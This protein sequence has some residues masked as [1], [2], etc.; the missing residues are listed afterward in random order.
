MSTRLNT[1]LR[2]RIIEN[3]L[4]KAGVDAAQLQVDA[5]YNT[6]A[7]DLRVF[8]NGAPDSAL[9]AAEKKALKAAK[10]IPEHLLG[11]EPALLRR[12][13]YYTVN[14]AGASLQPH[15]LDANG[16]H[17]ERIIPRQRLAVLADNPLVQ[18]FYDIEARKEAIK[19]K[20]TTLRAQVKAA[21]N[22]VTTV[23]SLLK[24]WPEAKELL[25]ANL[26]EAKSQLPAL[27]VTDL[28]A[29][30]GLPTEKAA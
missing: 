19:D 12:S 22:T 13:A 6:W 26:E 29:L 7:E 23:A 5:D 10:E 30:I 25:P 24:N 1:H 15:L 28:N 21:I 18:R 4:T 2:A 20:R 17:E 27:A 16:A 14:L 11:A 3:A 8:L 9:I